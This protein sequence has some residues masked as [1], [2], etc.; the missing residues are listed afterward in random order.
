MGNH[1]TRPITFQQSPADFPLTVELGRKVPEWGLRRFNGGGLRLRPDGEEGF[2]FRCDKQRVLYKGRNK[3]HRF[4]ILGQD[5][6]EYDCILNREPKSN[7]VTLFL[8][9]AENYDFLRQPDWVRDPF[10][11]GS[12]AVYKKETFIG[13]GTGKLCHIHRPKIIDARGRWVW[14]SLSIVGDRLII[15][16]PE[17]W[18]GEAMY[19]VIVDP[20]VGTNTVGSQYEWYDS[21]DEEYKGLY[22]E[23]KLIVNRFLIPETLNGNANAYV[24]AWDSD[25]GSICKPAL[26]SDNNNVPLT[27][28]STLE[29]NIDIQIKSGKSPGWR[30]TTFRS[31]AS[32]AAGTYLW[33]GVYSDWFGMRFDYGTKCYLDYCDLNGN[34]LPNTYPV[35]S[36][37][38]YYNFKPSMYFD[39]TSVQ[40]YTRTLTQGVTL[41]DAR[42]LIGTYKRTETQTVKNTTVIKQSENLLRKCLMNVQS[43]MALKRAPTFIRAIVQQVKASMVTGNKRNISRA[44]VTLTNIASVTTRKGDN[45]RTVKDSNKPE[46]MLVRKAEINR[47]MQT[48]SGVNDSLIKIMNFPRI[49]IDTLRPLALPRVISA[50]LRK[51]GTQT[52]L[53]G[54]IGRSLNIRREAIT[55]AKALDTLNRKPVFVRI[56][57]NMLA[58]SGSSQ[59]PVIFVR[60][61]PEINGI[62]DTTGHWGSYI[63]G[64]YTAVQGTSGMYHITDYYR[65][66]EDTANTEAIPMRH[67]IIFICLA[68]IGFV[69]DFIINRFLKSNEDIRL[70]SP[71]CRDI[72]L[73]S[74]I[75]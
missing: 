61:L 43:T 50:F 31:N 54:N 74:Y 3:S 37:S 71:V 7:T 13:E 36:A 65:K 14:G 60:R 24:Y 15:T 1:N 42:K 73:D 26:Y 49:I 9:G 51:I 45:K 59:H 38:Q 2:S 29:G 28:R 40:N 32:I 48:S 5:R 44:L 53:S 68:T 47:K 35:Y 41:S 56:I 10:L 58:I 55:T 20:V 75:H 12:Y 8:D 23:E 22:V 62:S 57:L 69:R 19:P 52:G 11:A 30:N 70:K 64:I 34:E 39:Y 72:E 25:Y 33:F 63:R 66:Q 18:L 46:M 21:D 16:I 67:L 17:G 4:T 27:R 6:F